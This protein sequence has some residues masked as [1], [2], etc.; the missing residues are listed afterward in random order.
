[1]VFFAL[2][3]YREGHRVESILEGEAI[4]LPYKPDPKKLQGSF[5]SPKQHFRVAPS[6]SLGHALLEE[7]VDGGRADR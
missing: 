2:F 1:M 7:E 6:A 4:R 3:H 5:R